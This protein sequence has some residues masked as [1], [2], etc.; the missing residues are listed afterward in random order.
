M[1]QRVNVILEDDIEGGEAA[2]TV[3]F[4]LDG[5]SYEIDLS[6]A[7]AQKLRDSL[8]QWI[9]A[10]RRV[11]GRKAPARGASKGRSSGRGD[12]ALIREWAG[13]HGYQVSERGRIPAEVRAAYEAAN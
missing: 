7:N 1:V 5:V 11:S 4:G 13:A 8:A 6:E 3:T 10:G 9:G 12:A 2:E